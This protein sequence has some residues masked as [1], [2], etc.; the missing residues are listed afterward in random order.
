[1]GQ[2]FT[3]TANNFC[4]GLTVVPQDFNT[5]YH[6][7][8]GVGA[9]NGVYRST[10]AGQSWTLLS[11]AVNGEDVGRLDIGVSR[12]GARVYIGGQKGNEIVIQRSDDA[13]ANWNAPTATAIPNANDGA[14]GNAL[15]YCESQCD[16]GNVVSVNPFDPNDVWL[17]GVGLYRST[18]GG[19][20][21]SRVGENNTPAAPGPGPLH[22][23]H[24]VLL[25]HPTIPGRL[26]NGND[27]G[28]YRSGDGG[29]SWESLS[30]TLAT[31]QHYH[32]SLHP[33]DPNVVFTGNQDNGTTRRT[34]SDTWTEVA[35]GDGGFSAV[36]HGNPQIV[37]ASTTE[38]NI[39]KST[40]GGNSFFRAGFNFGNDPVQFIA[41]FVM[42]PLDARTL[43]AGTHRLWR[44]DNGGSSWAP[45]SAP[46][47]ETPRSSG[48]RALVSAPHSIRS[49]SASP[50][51]PECRP[52]SR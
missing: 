23:D 45:I 36:D 49:T 24:H 7:A 4:R 26:Y 6:S 16:Y 37:Y 42:D 3:Q 12:D 41:P 2:S 27:G 13:G 21:F 44:T 19:S 35:G 15:S 33:T 22:V 14:A 47:I 17:G 48:L 34:T 9:Q 50:T 28:I 1:G 52:R 31:L 39:L 46:L 25:F 51:M 20:N 11:G 32:L 29:A 43:Y 38:L 40:N 10:D 18:D 8:T 5:M 30:G